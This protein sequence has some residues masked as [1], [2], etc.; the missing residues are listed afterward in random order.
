LFPVGLEGVAAWLELF[1][2]VQEA[3]KIKKR[4]KT[5]DKKD[6]F[7]TKSINLLSV[8]WQMSLMGYFVIGF[9]PLRRVVEQKRHRI[10]TC[11]R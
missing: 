9:K 5:Y 8:F 10:D 1:W 11:K 2:T 3:R 7:L 6:S 4:L